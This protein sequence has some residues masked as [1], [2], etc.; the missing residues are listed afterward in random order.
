M[1]EQCDA[2]K[3]RD[4]SFFFFSFQHENQVDFISQ[5]EFFDSLEGTIPKQTCQPKAYKAGRA[6]IFPTEK[7]GGLVKN[8]GSQEFARGNKYT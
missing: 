5:K 4:I 1:D 6:Q 8:R 3:L 2:T 7:Q